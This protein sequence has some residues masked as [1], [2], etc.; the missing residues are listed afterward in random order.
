MVL[1]L[2]DSLTEFIRAADAVQSALYS[3]MQLLV[4]EELKELTLD[5]IVIL[6]EEDSVANGNYRVSVHVAGEVDPYDS[7]VF[8]AEKILEKYVNENRSYVTKVI[9]GTTITFN[10]NY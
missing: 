7:R 8:N 4:R 10:Y 9:I 5:K 2:T 1:K 6:D 3:D